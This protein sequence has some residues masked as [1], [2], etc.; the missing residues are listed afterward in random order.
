MENSEIIS[1]IS[2]IFFVV[3]FC[4]LIWYKKFKHNCK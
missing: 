2:G 3:S 4:L 1:L